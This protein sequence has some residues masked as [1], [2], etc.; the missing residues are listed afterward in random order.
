MEPHPDG[1]DGLLGVEVELL[2]EVVSEELL[3]GALAGGVDG[4]VEGEA[5]GGVPP[6]RSLVLLD[7]DWL[8]A[9]ARVATSANAHRPPSNFFMRPPPE[10]VTR[11]NAAMPMPSLDTRR[12]LSYY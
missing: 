12:R 11:G 7:G 10:R 4:V 5:E 1:E 6:G 9:L 8:Q 3:P 2:P